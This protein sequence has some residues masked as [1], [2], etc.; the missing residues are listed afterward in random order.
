MG[1]VFNI[2][3]VLN[4]FLKSVFILL[5]MKLYDVYKKLKEILLYMIK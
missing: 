5:S 2:L 4:T 1:V 3:V